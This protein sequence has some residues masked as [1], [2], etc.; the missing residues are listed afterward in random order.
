MIQTSENY[1]FELISVSKILLN[2]RVI[3]LR[4]KSKSFFVNMH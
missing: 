2:K 4:Y 3:C 1:D